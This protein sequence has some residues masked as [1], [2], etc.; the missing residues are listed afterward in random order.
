MIGTFSVLEDQSVLL[1]RRQKHHTCAIA[2]K[3]DRGEAHHPLVLLLIV[4]A[5]VSAKT[6]KSAHCRFHSQQLKNA[7]RLL[8]VVGG[9][10]SLTKLLLRV[11]R[12]VSHEG[13]LILGWF[14]HRICRPRSI[15][16][17]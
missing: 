11:F 8:P 9:L 6:L 4:V 12:Q 16:D 3:P 1:C 2:S 10:R 15:T 5:L 17:L 13:A 7:F 14:H